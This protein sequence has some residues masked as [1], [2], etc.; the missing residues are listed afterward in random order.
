MLKNL[1]KI[2]SKQIGLLLM[3]FISNYIISVFFLLFFE[4]NKFSQFHNPSEKQIKQHI[5]NYLKRVKLTVFAS[6]SNTTNQYFTLFF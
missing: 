6:I 3:F 4:L 5:L 1:N 2:Q